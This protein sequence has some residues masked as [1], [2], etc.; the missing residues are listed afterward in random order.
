[1]EMQMELLGMN[2]TCLLLSIQNLDLPAKDC[3]LPI[4][5]KALGYC[6]ITASTVVKVPQIYLILKNNSIKGLSPASFELEVVGYTI[7]F[8]YCFN[9]KLPFLAYGELSFLLIQALILVGLIYNY[10]RTLK[11]TNWVTAAI[12]CALAPTVLAGGLN[13]FLLEVLYASQHAILF[14]SKLPQITKNFMSKNTG[15]LSFI[16]CFMNF[17]GSLARTFTSVQERAPISMLV[18]CCLGIITNG[19]LVSQIL[20]YRYSTVKRKKSH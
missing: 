9:K 5:S 1:M 10:S 16:T 18:G 8:A 19:I 3:L 11:T 6:I 14:C 17:G 2:F 13:P 15:Q 4:I 20:L 12:Y 7:A